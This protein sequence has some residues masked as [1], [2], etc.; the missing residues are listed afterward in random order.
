[1]K[2]L[3]DTD[4]RI[5]SLLQ[6]D[7]R[8]SLAVIG[9]KVGLAA[10]SVNDRI[11]RLVGSGAIQGFHAR[12]GPEALGL[13][14]LAFIFVGWSDPAAEAPFLKRIA[15]A[16]S[17]QECHH[18]TGAWNYLLK[19]RL[20]NT[21]QLEQ[22]LNDVVKGVRGVQRTETLIVL[23][24]AKEGSALPLAVETAVRK[25]RSRRT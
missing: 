21:R 22:F 18:V 9:N 25:P 8:L 1:M 23:S 16:P 20:P 13:E 3:D 19:V 24:T 7:D 14:L 12:V 15:A 4:L 10:S 5:L 2:R 17:V 11:K 6:E